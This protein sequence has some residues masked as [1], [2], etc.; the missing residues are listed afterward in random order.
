MLASPIS[1][2]WGFAAQGSPS[3]T[4]TQYA[5]EQGGTGDPGGLLQASPMKRGVLHAGPC[6]VKGNLPTALQASSVT[7]HWFYIVA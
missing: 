7:H 6:H 4:H 2:C 5:D 3:R 1:I